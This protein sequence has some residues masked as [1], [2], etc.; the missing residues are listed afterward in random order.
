VEG[1]T[2]EVA[3][4]KRMEPYVAEALERSIDSW[5]RI[6]KSWFPLR[7]KLGSSECPLCIIFIDE[8]C[9]GCP[10][11]QKTGKPLCNGTP[12]IEVATAHSSRNTSEFRVHAKREFEFLKSLRD[13]RG[14]A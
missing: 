3:V 8:D 11:K 14:V 1:G 2:G 12:Y 9:R 7:K 13:E 5:E 10:V 6:C 4:N